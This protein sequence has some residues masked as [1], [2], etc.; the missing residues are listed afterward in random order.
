MKSVL[1]RLLVVALISL[2]LFGTATFIISM[3][4][5][6]AL[7]LLGALY[8]NWVFSTAAEHLMNLFPVAIVFSVLVSVSLFV[9]HFHVVR[10]TGRLALLRTI[11]AVALTAG[12]VHAV[13]VLSIVPIAGEAGNEAMA[14]TAAVEHHRQRFDAQ[15]NAGR[16]ALARTHVETIARIVPELED[17]VEE[18][19]SRLRDAEERT[20]E[21]AGGD[22]TDRPT[23]RRRPRGQTASDSLNRAREA[24]D[25]GDWFTAHLYARRAFDVDPRL[26]E[27]R[28]LAENAWDE[29]E[30]AARESD[31]TRLFE[32]KRA[33]L[34][35]LTE[36]RPIEAYYLFRDLSDE[37]PGDP[38]VARYLSE[39]QQA[40]SEIAF[41]V[42]DVED[43]AG[44]PGQSDVIYMQESDE[45]RYEL[46]HFDRLVGAPAV[47]LVIGVEAIG[48]HESGQ[49]AY[50]FRAPV[51][52]FIDG[53]L[54][55]RALDPD[56]A[57]AGSDAEYLY[58]SRPEGMESVIPLETSTTQLLRVS[59][60]QSAPTRLNA[61]DLFRILD[62]TAIGLFVRESA[63]QELMSRL[64]APFTAFISVVLGAC[65]AF[66]GRSRYAERPPVLSLLLLPVLALAAVAGVTV[67]S[68]LQDVFAGLALIAL[69]FVGALAVLLLVQAVF[70]FVSLA[71]AVRT[72]R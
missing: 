39:A 51:G 59:L 71:V 60:A 72:F 2:A 9:D 18:R 11:G 46:I 54:S 52:R 14:A 21:G 45:Y 10:S 30:R 53:N 16:F 25:E 3:L 57:G 70:M 49:P 15:L 37:H 23:P 41:F 33:G 28:T 56:E 66:R 6:P 32:R 68:Y 29:I 69:P 12:L 44:L 42:E 67:L 13:L 19:L 38:D 7:D 50:R 64:L 35:A 48:I 55:V 43:L 1:S 61:L 17:E 4:Q 40:V 27:A 24:F 26:S 5:V 62:D 36:G 31:R 22:P 63:E 34:R 65:V 8:W 47:R 58:G 20:A